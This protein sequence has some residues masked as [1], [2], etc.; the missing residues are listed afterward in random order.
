MRA[1]H[2]APN[3]LSAESLE[4]INQLSLLL[5]QYAKNNR[6]P[7]IHP[8]GREAAAHFALT[9]R[10]ALIE[11]LIDET[12]FLLAQTNTAIAELERCIEADQRLLHLGT[13]LPEAL[14]IYQ[15]KIMHALAA[16]AQDLLDLTQ[17]AQRRT[18]RM[19]RLVRQELLGALRMEVN[20]INACLVLGA[21]QDHSL[22]DGFE[23]MTLEGMVAPRQELSAVWQFGGSDGE[24]ALC[25][26]QLNS[27]SNDVRGFLDKLT[28]TAQ[29]RKVAQERKTSTSFFNQRALQFGFYAVFLMIEWLIVRWGFT[30]EHPSLVVLL[31]STM[32]M[33]A[34]W[35]LR[36]NTLCPQCGQAFVRIKVADQLVRPPPP[37]KPPETST[38]ITDTEGR[39]IGNLVNPN[40]PNHPNTTQV[41]TAAE[42]AVVHSCCEKCNFVWSSRPA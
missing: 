19:R 22:M 7:S 27:F 1:R 16:A 8:I 5:D 38:R 2:Q 36:N 11:N 15:S 30:N 31:G 21:L 10:L 3:E 20:D 37:D 12:P 6:L 29:I 25:L 13:R 24:R 17:P 33:V 34:L 4:K 28:Q 14:K 42:A 18:Q 32:A 39:H 23:K 26:R 41:K 40:T 9:L 35:V